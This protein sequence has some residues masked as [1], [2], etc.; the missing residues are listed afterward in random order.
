MPFSGCAQDNLSCPQRVAD[1]LKST[2]SQTQKT[3]KSAVGRSKKNICN[4]LKQVKSVWSE[5]A[6]IDFQASST[7]ATVRNTEG[8]LPL[9]SRRDPLKTN[10]NTRRRDRP[11]HNFVID[12][13]AAGTE[14]MGNSSNLLVAGKNQASDCKRRKVDFYDEEEL[15]LLVDF[16]ASESPN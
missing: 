16:C 15:S 7:S 9:K 3:V 8:C 5:D 10:D 4:D 6:K 1:F 2:S 13:L 14:Q 11:Q 12:L